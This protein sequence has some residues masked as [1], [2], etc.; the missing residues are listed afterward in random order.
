MNLMSLFALF[1]QVVGTIEEAVLRHSLGLGNL[2]CQ[3]SSAFFRCQAFKCASLLLIFHQVVG[4]IEKLFFGILQVQDIYA[5]GVH[6]PRVIA[7]YDINALFKCRSSPHHRMFLIYVS[8]LA[9]LILETTCS[10]NNIMCSTTNS[11]QL[12]YN[13]GIYF[14]NKLAMYRYGRRQASRGHRRCWVVLG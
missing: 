2:R 4:T 10:A 8:C 5:Y 13:F 1:Y 11:K 7:L 6:L 3:C 12:H 14:C 9:Y